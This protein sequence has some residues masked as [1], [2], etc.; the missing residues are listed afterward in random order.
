MN[1]ERPLDLLAFGQTR[2]RLALLASRPDLDPVNLFHL[3]PSLTPP[4]LARALRPKRPFWA[5]YHSTR[6]GPNPYPWVGD[7]HFQVNLSKMQPFYT[8]LGEGRSVHKTFST[9][10]ILRLYR[11][12]AKRDR[13]KTEKGP[14]AIRFFKRFLLRY[15]LRAETTAVCSGYRRRYSFFLAT[16]LLPFARAYALDLIF[17]P[18]A[19]TGAFSFRR[20]KAIKRRIRKRLGVRGK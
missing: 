10:C 2:A 16:A 4:H 3:L 19:L 8:T 1:A 9:G 13:R 18:K 14:L 6:L 15:L 7:Y 12:V 11:V 20:V 17:A 5:L